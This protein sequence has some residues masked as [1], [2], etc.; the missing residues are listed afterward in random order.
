MLCHRMSQPQLWL[1]K[2]VQGQRRI[3]NS[4][5]ARLPALLQ[6]FDFGCVISVCWPYIYTSLSHL[7]LGSYN[8]F[9]TNYCSWFKEI[10]TH[11]LR[12]CPIN[13]RR[14][15]AYWVKSPLT[16]RL[17][18]LIRTYGFIFH[19]RSIFL[20]ECI[21]IWSTEIKDVF[22]LRTYLL[23]PPSTKGFQCEAKSL[24]AATTWRRRNF[25]FFPSCQTEV[26]YPQHT[27]R[28]GRSPGPAEWPISSKIKFQ[29][30][31]IFYKL[32]IK[33]LLKSY[34]PPHRLR[35]KSSTWKQY[36]ASIKWQ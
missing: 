29:S 25:H 5:L 6:K 16:L 35:L 28:P 30:E 21:F 13:C 17:L 34:L 32:I 23:L 27:K 4:A 15:T 33:Q 18:K 26:P 9:K 11:S 24:P 20:S 7:Q 10:K 31:I 2:E 3:L 19:H 22:K 8:K 12:E 14:R 36:N 1:R